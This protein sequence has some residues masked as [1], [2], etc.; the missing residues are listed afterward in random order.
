ML[1]EELEASGRFFLLIASR[2]RPVWVTARRHIYGEILEMTETDIA[3]VD[4]E[5]AEV[6]NGRGNVKLLRQ[7]ARGWPALVALAALAD[8]DDPHPRAITTPSD[9][10]RLYSL[11]K[12]TAVWRSEPK[13]LSFASPYYRL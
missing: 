1:V 4:S 8:S 6:M 3:L 5:A 11:M 12:Y 2:T 13:C 9:A 10:L 7:E